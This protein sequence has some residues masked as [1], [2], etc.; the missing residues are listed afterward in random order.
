MIGLFISQR[1]LFRAKTSSSSYLVHIMVD[2]TRIDQSK[3]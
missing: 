3:G 2:G 1:Q